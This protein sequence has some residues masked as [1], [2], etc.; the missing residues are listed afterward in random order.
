M[1]KSGRFAS[2]TPKVDKAQSQPRVTS[3][4]R[5]VPIIE[6]TEVN[7]AT[8]REAH[9]K[10]L[11]VRRPLRPKRF[12]KWRRRFASFNCCPTLSRRGRNRLASGRA[13]RAFGLD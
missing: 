12:S 7:P 4:A 9:P 13:E 6:P 10:S 2:R 5:P 1:A 3:D 8:S 11:R